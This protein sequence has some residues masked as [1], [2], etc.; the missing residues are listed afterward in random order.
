MTI[1]AWIFLGTT[2]AFAIAVA[3]LVIVMV[4]INRKKR[5]EVYD[6]VNK[7]FKFNTSMFELPA[8]RFYDIR[9]YAHSRIDLIYDKIKE[10]YVKLLYPFVQNMALSTDW[11]HL[12]SILIF[13]K[14]DLVRMTLESARYSTD[15]SNTIANALEK[16]FAE[17]FN[18]YH[19]NNDKIKAADIFNIL[20]QNK[21]LIK[22]EFG[23]IQLYII[24]SKNTLEKTLEKNKQDFY[25]FIRGV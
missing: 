12:Q 20:E 2:I 17:L 7:C 22:E 4:K 19:I 18:M 11:K 23:K 3:V 5:A 14:N 24:G 16:K 8:K 6:F 10:D 25:S 21:E 15:E 9:V 13:I 1:A